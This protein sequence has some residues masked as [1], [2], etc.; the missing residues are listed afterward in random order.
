ANAWVSF[1]YS[2]DE[3]LKARERSFSALDLAYLPEE[4]TGQEG[5]QYF[6]SSFPPQGRF[7]DYN[8]DGTP[9]VYNYGDP[10]NGDLFN[11]GSVRDL[12]SPVKRR[13]AMAGITYELADGIS[14]S[15]TLNWSEVN[16]ETEFETFPLDL[17]DNIWD[18][19]RGGTGGLDINSPL[20]PEG[21][22]QS[23]VAEGITNI[24]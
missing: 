7:G 12:A 2:D 3:G 13:L 16:V 8:G 23:L 1:G 6:G 17:V 24:N 9:F 21:L 18:N 20:I 19:D 11:R 15:M 4:V 22:R 5:W 10:E 14:T